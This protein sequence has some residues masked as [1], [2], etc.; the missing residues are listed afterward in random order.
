[1]LRIKGNITDENPRVP[2]PAAP[3]RHKMKVQMRFTDIDMLGHVNNNAYLSYM[4]LAKVNYFSEVLPEGM[5]WRTVSAVIVHI[6]CDYFSPAYF[7][8]PLVVSTTIVSVSQRSFRMEQRVVNDVTGQTKCVCTTIMA[9]FD[10]K[11]A[12]GRPLDRFWVEH[13]ERYESRTL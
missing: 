12:V 10:P 1:M 11:T 7:E 6:D 5:D 13:V 9:G 3:F 8:E 2:A 4:D